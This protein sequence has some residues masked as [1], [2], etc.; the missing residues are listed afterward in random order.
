MYRTS[1][2]ANLLGVTSSTINRWIKSGKLKA[3]RT[4]G[5]HHRIEEG[6]V[7]K[8]QQRARDPWRL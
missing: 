8:L 2:V 6:E 5:G 3:I 4:E 7:D 1:Q